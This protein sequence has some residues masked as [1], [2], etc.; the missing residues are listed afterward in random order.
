MALA[1]DAPV[2][3]K[4]RRE[5]VAVSEPA[6]ALPSDDLPT[7]LAASR[8]A[9]LS[10]ASEVARELV[11]GGSASD[12]VVTAIARLP[13][14]SMRN[15]LVEAS[16]AH[17]EVADALVLARASPLDAISDRRAAKILAVAASRWPAIAKRI[18]VTV[19]AS[20]LVAE[21]VSFARDVRRIIHAD[22]KL[23]ES[24]KYERGFDTAASVGRVIGRVM[25]AIERC[26]TELQAERCMEALDEI[27]GEMLGADGETHKAMLGCGGAVIGLENALEIMVDVLHDLD[28]LADFE[29][30]YERIGRD[31]DAYGHEQIS[32]LAA[33]VKE[34]LD[35]ELG[36]DSADE[37]DDE[38]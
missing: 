4:R 30:M 34:T 25:E 21:D 31:Y 10:A 5:D 38:A 23:R 13:V 27:A 14:E 2:G 22:D 17:R 20:Q 24:V 32:C 9:R 29:D 7:R 36:D 3:S 33:R 16:L 19:A 15:E 12:D 37:D 6:P 28:M 26:P 1:P 35:D 11:D 18:D 8:L